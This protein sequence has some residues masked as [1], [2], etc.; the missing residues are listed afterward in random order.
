METPANPFAANSR[1]A[2]DSNLSL[3]SCGIFSSANA[4][5]PFDSPAYIRFLINR[6]IKL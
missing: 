5:T 2:A 4:V 3:A 1:V 6:L